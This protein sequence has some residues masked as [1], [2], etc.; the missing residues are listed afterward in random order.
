MPSWHDV[1]QVVVLRHFAPSWRE[2]ALVC[3][4]LQR[5]TGRRKCRVRGDT[6]G[7]QSLGYG[8]LDKRLHRCVT[9]TKVA[10]R[11][12]IGMIEFHIGL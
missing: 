8:S 5:L 9:V 11:M 10:M 1:D 12:I 6:I 3:I 2:V 7:S 4:G